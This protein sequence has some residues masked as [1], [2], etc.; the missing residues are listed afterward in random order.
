MNLLVASLINHSSPNAVVP[1]VLRQATN[2]ELSILLDIH[3]GIHNARS[4]LGSKPFET[5]YPTVPLK[6]S[7]KKPLLSCRTPSDYVNFYTKT[8]SSLSM[9]M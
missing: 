8:T 9:R 3:L 2:H 6:S 7:K 4:P 5:L 1:V